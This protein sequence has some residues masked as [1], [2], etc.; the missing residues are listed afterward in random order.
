MVAC[1]FSK[2]CS[3]LTAAIVALCWHLLQF[4][5]QCCSRQP[6]IICS[7]VAKY[8]YTPK[9]VDNDSHSLYFKYLDGY[10]CLV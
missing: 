2:N 5:L 10:L 7:F 4:T 6:R 3:T 1:T 8:Y 9:Q